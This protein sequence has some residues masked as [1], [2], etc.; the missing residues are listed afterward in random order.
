[1]RIPSSEIFRANQ[2]GSWTI[3]RP[4]KIGGA[5]LKNITFNGG[6]RIAGINLMDLPGK[7]LEVE[8]LDADILVIKGYY[9]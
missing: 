7:D 2:N 3:I 8:D 4:I 5:T 6:V 1:M 9:N